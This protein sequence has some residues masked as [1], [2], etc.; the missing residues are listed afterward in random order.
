[1][2]IGAAVWVFAD[3]S[4]LSGG[5]ALLTIAVVGWSWLLMFAVR[6]LAV[7]GRLRVVA[8][9]EAVSSPLWTLRWDRVSAVSIGAVG[10]N[11]AL[12]IEPIRASDVQPGP[13]R[14]IR[15]NRQMSQL[16]ENGRI[17]ILEANIDR[18]VEQLALDLERQAGRELTVSNAQ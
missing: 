16:F 14:I 6:R 4:I 13:S 10:G 9:R 11:R 12:F 18:P 1:M 7:K 3:P 15:L 2:V 17:T 5:F 8:T